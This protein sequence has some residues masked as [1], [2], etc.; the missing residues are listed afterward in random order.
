MRVPAGVTDG[1]RIRVKGRGGAG[2]N[3]GPP[4]DLFVVVG[5]Q[6]HPLFGRSGNDLTIR[7][8]VTFAEATLGADVKVPTLDGQVTMRIPP[9]TPSGKVM[10]VRGQ[11][12]DGEKTENLL[13]TVEVIVPTELNEHQREAVQAMAEAFDED[14]RA[15]LFEKQHNRRSSDG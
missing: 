13:V 8:P 2:A 15:A 6:S 11:A 9:G 12:A 4:G 1:Q 3:G 14:P 10:R 7:L 5:V